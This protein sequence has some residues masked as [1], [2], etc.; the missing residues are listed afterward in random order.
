ML[1]KPFE[2]ILNLE[3]A[4][5]SIIYTDKNHTYEIDG[6]PARY[7]VTKLLSKYQKPFDSDTIAGFVARKQG[8]EKEDVLAKWD[9]ERDY[10]NHKGTEFHLYVENFLARK[11]I[12]IDREALEK[13]FEKRPNFAFAGSISAY[14]QELAKMINNFNIFYS[15]Y[16]P[17]YK[18]LKSELVIG[19]KKCNIAGTLDN[20][21]F[22]IETGDLHIF[23]YKTNKAINTKSKYG[24]KLLAPFDHLE[25]CELVKYSLQLWLYRL[26][27]QRNTA[28]KVKDCKILWFR[29]EEYTMFDILNLEEEAKKM[30]EIEEM[31]QQDNK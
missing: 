24:N 26:I 25:D 1:L 23:D 11:K 9:Y 15:W 14:Y 22:D 29:G 28:F 16:A 8:V 12:Q 4:F 17:K 18:L 31:Y 6:K 5:S 7:S 2:D 21:S 3:E 19:D 13:F 30:L 20:L 27:I 10:A